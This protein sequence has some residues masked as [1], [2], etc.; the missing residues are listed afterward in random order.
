MQ[1]PSK[2]FMAKREAASLAFVNGDAK[3][4]LDLSATGTAASIFGPPGTI[5]SGGSEVNAANA[6]GAKMFRP[7]G[8]SHFEPVQSGQSGELAFWC[9]IQRSTVIMGESA[10]P[11][12]MDL[13]VTEI[14]QRMDGTWKLIH[15]HADELKD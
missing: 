14:F 15:R 8:K 9:G 6:H 2:E 12:E 11:K 1:H 3:P 10:D 7:G 4:L 13:R 5:V